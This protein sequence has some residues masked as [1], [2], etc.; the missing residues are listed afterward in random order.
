MH[1]PWCSIDS[2]VCLF[3]CTFLCCDVTHSRYIIWSALD[4]ASSMCCDFFL[5][6]NLSTS[7]CLSV[8]VPRRDDQKHKGGGTR[9]QL[10]PPPRHRPGYQ[11]ARNQDGATRR[12]QCCDQISV[13]NR[14]HFLYACIEDLSVKHDE[15]IIKKICCNGELLL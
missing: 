1:I 15:V 6:H 14:T 4:P 5:C 9:L 12:G 3:N 13:L 2:H 7:V 8:V 10:S 11:G